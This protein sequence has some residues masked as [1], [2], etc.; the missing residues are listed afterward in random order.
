MWR[1][2][3][4]ALLG[5]AVFAAAMTG[6]SAPTLSL[7][8]PDVEIGGTTVST[9]SKGFFSSG[10]ADGAPR[11]PSLVRLSNADGV[12][13]HVHTNLAAKD[14]K[15]QIQQGAWNER[16]TVQTLDLRSLEAP[17]HLAPSD[18]PYFIFVSVNADV[19]SMT[20]VFGVVVAR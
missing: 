13:L 2:N 18:Q 1:R 17:I 12:D 19:G 14:A 6:C 4:A 16:S 7:I 15:V 11:E 5:V 3:T 20:A 8:G 9:C 10:C